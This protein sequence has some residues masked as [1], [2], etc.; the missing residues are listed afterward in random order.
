MLKYRGNSLKYIED[1]MY[2]KFSNIDSQEDIN[3][4]GSWSWNTLDWD[5]KVESIRRIKS[6]RCN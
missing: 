3:I 1:C 6:R 4:C 5:M 2:G